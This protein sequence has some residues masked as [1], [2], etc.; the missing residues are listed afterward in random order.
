MIMRF[1]SLAAFALA[2]TFG[3]YLILP[4]SAQTS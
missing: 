2:A 4:L 1:I 3:A